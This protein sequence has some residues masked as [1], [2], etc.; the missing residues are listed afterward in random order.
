MKTTS[1]F[2]LFLFI[3]GSTHAQIGNVP[4]VYSEIHDTTYDYR[5]HGFI[6]T[7]RNIISNFGL[8]PTHKS[9]CGAVLL[10]N[11]SDI[12]KAAFNPVD[13]LG[14]IFSV[15]QAFQHFDDGSYSMWLIGNDQFGY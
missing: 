7:T 4:L 9:P 10:E 14:E 3:I 13:T 1:L 11:G 8:P 6:Y 12:F 15:S 5:D 2:I